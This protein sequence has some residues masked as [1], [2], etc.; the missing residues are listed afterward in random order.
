MKLDLGYL[1]RIDDVCPGMDEDKFERIEKIFD[2]YQVKPLIGIIPLNKDESLK[3]NKTAKYDLQF[4]GKMKSL[5]SK[6]WIVAQHGYEHKY[7]ND[8]S[9]LLGITEHSEFC[10]LDYEEQFRKVGEGKK[11]LEE[12]LKT[13]IEWWMAPAH[14]FDKV[15]INVLVDLGFKKITDGI[16]LF[17][18]KEF[19]LEWFPQQLWQPVKMPFGFWTV[20]LHLNTMKSEDFKK[21]E[22][23]LGKNSKSDLNGSKFELKSLFLKNILNR[24]FAGFWYLLLRFKKF[25]EK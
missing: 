3:I 17:P 10:G 11:I 1:F 19:G 24:I 23:F 16:A 9:G 4:W 7:I 5:I 2:K 18:F 25:F 22:D 20:C 12:K 21:L 15:T 13:K 6:G 8:C 14:S